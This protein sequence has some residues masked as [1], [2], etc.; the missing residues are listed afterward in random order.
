MSEEKK[1]ANFNNNFQNIYKIFEKLKP[2]LETVFAKF[3]R[4]YNERDISAINKLN[5]L[6]PFMAWDIPNNDDL[7]K[8]LKLSKE[9]DIANTE[10]IL[11]YIISELEKSEAIDKDTN[12]YVNDVSAKL[13]MYKDKK[14]KENLHRIYL[15]YMKWY[16]NKLANLPGLK[17]FWGDKRKKL[18]ER[19]NKSELIDDVK[20]MKEDDSDQVQ[21]HLSSLKGIL[22]EKVD[23]YKKISDAIDKEQLHWAALNEKELEKLNVEYKKESELK[24]DDNKSDWKYSSKWERI[25]Q[26]N[27]D[28][29][30]RQ[31]LAL[32][33]SI[34]EEQKLKEETK[35]SLLHWAILAKGEI[36]EI[37]KRLSSFWVDYKVEKKSRRAYRW[38]TLEK[39]FE[40]KKAAQE[41]QKAKMEEER[42]RQ[43]EKERR[44]KEEAEKEEGGERE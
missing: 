34:I 23:S 2:L 31:R 5:M 27:I 36:D 6:F 17:F 8:L 33:K 24:F 9:S 15:S 21:N 25:K 44:K 40:R 38:E 10:A 30:E 37:E 39:E 26:E 13:K 1:M 11:L 29:I 32:V 28:K 35:E 4:N 18:I 7:E 3:P 12:K 14:E 41:A 20:Q 42:K 16:K 19:V 22:E 43:E